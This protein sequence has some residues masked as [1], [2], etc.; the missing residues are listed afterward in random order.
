MYSESSTFV[1]NL[2]I[3]AGP[4]GLAVMKEL[5]CNGLPFLGLESHEEI[6]GLWNIRNPQ[7]PAYP[8][9]TTNSS[10]STTYL[11]KKAPHDWPSYFSQKDAYRYLI[12]FAERYTLS[13]EIRFN[14]KVTKIKKQDANLWSVYFTD[15]KSG[16]EHNIT[17][18]NLVVCT[19]VHTT[20]NKF[21]PLELQD[22][23]NGSGIECI[24]SSQFKDPSSYAG[25]CVLIVG[26]G[27][28]AADIATAVCTVA[29]R[30]LLSARSVPWVIPLWVLGLPADQFRG[31][32][33][34]T[35]IPFPIQNI[36]FHFLQ[37]L[38]IG[39]PENLGLGPIH[40]DLLDCLPVSD[41]GLMRAI[42]QRRIR[43]CGPVDRV[44]GNAVSFKLRGEPVEA[45]DKV[46]FA[47]GYKRDYPFLDDEFLQPLLQEDKA[48][49]LLIFHPNQESLFF[50]SE[51][52]VPQGS[53]PLFAKQAQAIASYLKVEGRPGNN[54]YRFN[55]T[56][57]RENPDYKGRI[58]R[59]EDRYHVDPNI[60]AKQ[61]DRFCD[62]IRR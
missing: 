10:K 18:N 15:R 43:L 21:V 28:S 20:S 27:N 3:G 23:F 54:F 44:E 2:V 58:F 9:L 8:N 52:S 14:S 35:S 46:I 56:R 32:A 30:T 24:H 51:V 61:I 59:C 41:R 5:K 39:H 26:F 4:A 25:Q 55:D 62:W 49:P 40:H 34:Y 29:K 12:D 37:R 6:G 53:W 45:V 47:T 57:H 17:T 19:G 16:Q 38:Y 13:S 31:F 50:A 1:A 60:Y 7:S 48:F 22:K 11:D 33:N 42:R 36:V